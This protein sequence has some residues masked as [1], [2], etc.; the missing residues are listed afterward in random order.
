MKDNKVK[1]QAKFFIKL[2]SRP[3]SMT[4]PVN[5]PRPVGDVAALNSAVK[6]ELLLSVS[7]MRQ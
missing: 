4:T 7:T 5:T 6:C 2:R 1:Q 3:V